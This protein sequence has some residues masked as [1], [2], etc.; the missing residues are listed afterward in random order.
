MVSVSFWHFFP[1]KSLT[2]YI[3]KIGCFM[4]N[5]NWVLISI[6]Y[7]HCS[8]FL[9]FLMWKLVKENRKTL[10][11]E[12]G[13]FYIVYS[14]DITSLGYMEDDRNKVSGHILKETLFGFALHKKHIFDLGIS[15]TILQ[16]KNSVRGKPIVCSQVRH[17]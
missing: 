6:G 4:N 1:Q 10:N 8:W 2:F 5:L 3:G 9:S 11:G 12:F 16:C 7:L 17:I 14:N 13:K 15:L